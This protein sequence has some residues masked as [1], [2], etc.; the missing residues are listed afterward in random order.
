M[1]SE[2]KEELIIGH[3]LGESDAED[4]A[5]VERWLQETPEN[6]D[7]YLRF[8]TML[9][10][11][12]QMAHQSPLSEQQAWDHFIHLRN[13]LPETK[14]VAKF[15]LYRWRNIAAV[16]LLLGI[17]LLSYRLFIEDLFFGR[18]IVLRSGDAVRIDTLPDGSVVH[19]N[20]HSQISYASRFEKNRHIA[21]RGEVYFDVVHNEE[22]PFTVTVQG[23]EIK[24]IG[25]IFNI[26]E[27][28]TQV[29]VVVESG[30]VSVK[31]GEEE[32]L[33][34]RNQRLN[35]NQ[36]ERILKVMNN[37]DP[38]YNLYASDIVR[39]NNLP[40]DKVLVVLNEL[41]HTNMKINDP[42]IGAVRITISFKKTDSFKTVWRIISET[43][44]EQ[45]DRMSKRI[46]GVPW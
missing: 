7:E 17:G 27:S 46:S 11:A 33:V 42:S 9:D 24:D 26:K 41:Y 23:L 1:K 25:T 10:T 8:K 14:P 32:A 45:K 31:K 35:I 30:I 2:I 15:G 12:G 34:H 3:I 43:S 28:P 20:K 44:P 37:E 39:I 21:M 29:A 4:R 13:E 19:L 36:N 6:R 38:L 18:Q 5:L 22:H 40:M 16:V